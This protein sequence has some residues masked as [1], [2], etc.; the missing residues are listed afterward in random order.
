MH[1]AT[2][3]RTDIRKLVDDFYGQIRVDPALGPIF[4]EH[5]D[6]WPSHLDTMV[7]FWSSLLLRTAD[8]TGSPMVKHGAI[9]NLSAELFER[10]LGLFQ[11]TCAEQPPELGERAWEFAQRIARS[12]W[13]GYQIQQRP[14]QNPSELSI[15][16]VGQ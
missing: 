11:T 10:W 9:P 13:M 7:S 5:I 3:D 15:P 8:F 4:N 12:L 2:F 14:D 6:D 1:T 16:I